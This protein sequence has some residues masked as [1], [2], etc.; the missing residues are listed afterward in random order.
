MIKDAAHTVARSVHAPRTLRGRFALDFEY[1][2]WATPYRDW[3]HASFLEVIERAVSTTSKAVTLSAG[4][5]SL[6]GRLDADPDADQVEVSACACTDQVGRMPPPPSSTRT[7]QRDA[8]DWASSR[9][10]E[11]L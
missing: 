3:L 4:S 6:D 1:E 11:S 7:T 2:D 10:L 5:T 9:P 8:R